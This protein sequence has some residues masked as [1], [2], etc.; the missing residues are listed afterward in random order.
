MKALR[1]AK[2]N[3]K[4]KTAKSAQQECGFEIVYLDVRP[5]TAHCPVSSGFLRTLQAVG[6]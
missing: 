6:R 1:L 4:L 2:G 5:A 3:S